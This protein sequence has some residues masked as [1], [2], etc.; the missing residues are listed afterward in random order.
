VDLSKGDG[1]VEAVV[2][3][4]RDVLLDVVIDGRAG[5][6][7]AYRLR[8]DRTST[9]AIDEDPDAGRLR[10]TWRGAESEVHV[11][12]SATGYQEARAKAVER[13]PG[14]P[15]VG[16]IELAS[17]GTLLVQVV[18]AADAVV[19]LI[20]APPPGGPGG[21]AEVNL[22]PHRVAGSRDLWR[23]QGL[24]PGAWAVRDL[25]TGVVST[26]EEVT[27]GGT[28]APARLDLSRAGIARGR[29]E[30]PDGY[31]RGEVRVV[32][33]GEGLRFGF[34]LSDD[35]PGMPVRSDGSF[36]I[37]VPGDRPVTLRPSHALLRPAAE[38]GRVTLTDPRE[39]IVL[40][41]VPGPQASL[42]P[43]PLPVAAREGWPS[44]NDLVRVL[45]YR[46]PTTA[47]PTA[48]IKAK[49]ADG[50]A[51]FGGFVAGTYGVFLDAYGSAPVFLP[52]VVLGDGA[53]DLGT[54]RF[55]AGGSVR[56]RVV[57]PE[58]QAPPAL[59]VEARSKTGPQHQRHVSSPG[60]ADVVLRGLGALRYEVTVRA[61]S[62][63]KTYLK[64]LVD[65]DGVGETELT[66][67]IR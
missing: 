40:R 36:T 17:A 48:T 62:G 59:L 28:S 56:A 39:G 1:R 31:V 2:R 50:V 53:T 6:P 34:G 32:A 18:P 42:R 43:D 67:E 25:T 29:V 65:S 63:D 9:T 57:V 49:F 3:S 27:P 7:A 10:C 64:R 45:L 11:L 24:R 23:L 51:R 66:V 47:L 4:A 15:L 12:L 35:L 8:V 58:G 14:G 26:R 16:R 5:L 20:G 21:L 38:G 19:D 13:S 22:R 30:V 60:A 54:V 52:A 46:G 41:T 33:E 44:A 37:R 61:S 55:P